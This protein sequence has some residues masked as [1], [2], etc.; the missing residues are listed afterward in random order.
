MPRSRLQRAG[1]EVVEV[2]IVFS[3]PG[4]GIVHIDL[5]V[6][7]KQLD[8]PVFEADCL[9]AGDASYQPG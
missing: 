2:A 1:K 9:P 8:Q 3:T 7:Y 4:L 5:E 6:P